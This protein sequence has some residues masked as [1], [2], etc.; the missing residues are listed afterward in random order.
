MTVK[1]PFKGN[2]FVAIFSQYDLG[3]LIHSRAIELGT[4]QTN[5]F[6]QSTQGKYVFRY[7][8]T[9]SRESVLF[10]R[11]L[12]LHLTKHQFPCPTQVKNSQG[13]IVGMYGN[14]P[15]VI[16]D[17]IEGE[18]IGNPSAHHWQ[19]LIQKAAE[20]QQITQDFYSKYS[21]FRWNYDADLCL[22]LARDEAT[23]INTPSAHAKLAWLTRELTTIDLPST[24]PRGICHCDFHY[25]NTLFQGNQLVALLDFDDA[26]YT[27]LQFDLVGLIEYCA[28]PRTAGKLDLSK[29]RDVVQE[30]MK[31]RQLSPIEQHHLYDVYK[32]SILFDCVW[33]FSRGASD[34]FLEKRKIESLDNLGRQRFF[35][36][37]FRN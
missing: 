37:L 30:Y 5:Y 4:V 9:R 31:H 1:T 34:H 32:L 3:A 25:S 19:Q 12:L 18:A 24:I 16:F 2:E 23:R 11:D 22:R 35:N 15:Y 29:A 14:K 27:F 26:N 7:F 20:L 13:T 36:E 21:S 8:E 17:F 33:Y 6:I 28:W 10:E